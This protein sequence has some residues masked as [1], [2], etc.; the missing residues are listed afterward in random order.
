MFLSDTQV[1][2]HEE[3]GGPFSGCSC[4]ASCRVDPKSLNHSLSVSSFILLYKQDYS[5]SAAILKKEATED[6]SSPYLRIVLPL[7][8]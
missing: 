5:D 2:R 8:H 7:R 3:A 4:M 1:S 6:L